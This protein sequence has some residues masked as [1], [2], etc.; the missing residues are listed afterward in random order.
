MLQWL[1]KQ[2]LDKILFVGLAGMTYAEEHLIDYLVQEDLCQFYWNT[3]KYFFENKNQEAG[4][5][6]R[7]YFKKWNQNSTEL[8]N[9]F[10]G[11]KNINI[12][13]ADNLV[14]Q[15]KLLGNLI[16]KTNFTEREITKTAVVLSDEN[17]LFP[18]LESI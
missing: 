17:L 16:E 8:R 10:L 7:K 14:G 11:K 9:D 5:F 12:I 2:N 1:K 3:D 18:V 15:A 13:G 6:A 4:F